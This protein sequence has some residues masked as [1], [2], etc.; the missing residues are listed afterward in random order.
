[1]YLSK[2]YCKLSLNIY[3]LFKYRVVRNVRNKNS[4]N[5]LSFLSKLTFPYILHFK[6][7]VTS[8]TLK[9]IFNISFTKYIE[10]NT[11]LSLRF[12]IQFRSPVYKRTYILHSQ[13]ECQKN[14]WSR[15]SDPAFCINKR[16]KP[17]LL[18]TRLK[19]AKQL[20]PRVGFH[21]LRLWQD[22]SGEIKLTL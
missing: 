8:A 18:Q 2:R 10:R 20:G 21:H 19:A 15:H 22:Y 17:L 4:V 13:R 12:C 7:S 3:K 11:K 5:K 1:M 14:D 6:L 9:G 16:N